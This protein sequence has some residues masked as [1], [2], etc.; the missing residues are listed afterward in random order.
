MV[1]ETIEFGATAYNVLAVFLKARLATARV[2]YRKTG[3]MHS[4]CMALQRKRCMHGSV[5]STE[6]PPQIYYVPPI[7]THCFLNA[8]L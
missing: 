3:L 2:A 1:V 6:Y 7:N 8:A 5:Y 4:E